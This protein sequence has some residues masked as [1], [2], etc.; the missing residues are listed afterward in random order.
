MTAKIP[1]FEKFNQG[2]TAKDILDQ[3]LV[4]DARPEFPVLCSNDLKKLAESCWNGNPLVRPTFEEIVQALQG[5]WLT[6]W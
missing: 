5:I 2:L 6:I 1:Y 4:S 3:I